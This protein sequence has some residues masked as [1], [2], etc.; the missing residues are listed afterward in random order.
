M[1]ITIN[2]EIAEK[3]KTFQ[4]PETFINS[5]LEEKISEHETKKENLED[6]VRQLTDDYQNN[7]ELTA[8]TDLDGE[9]FHAQR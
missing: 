2:D 7:S 5:L 4:N 1:Q 3:L 9:D 8:F 6:A